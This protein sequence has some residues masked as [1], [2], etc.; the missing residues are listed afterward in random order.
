MAVF[1]G[2]E[3]GTGLSSEQQE[4]QARDA[5][6]KE[7]ELYVSK[8]LYE[9]QAQFLI[10]TNY[11]YNKHKGGYNRA[12]ADQLPAKPALPACFEACAKFLPS[13][14]N[15]TD[16]TRATGPG[17]ATTGAQQ[18]V[19][20]DSAELDKWLLLVEENHDEVAELTSLPALQ[21][22]LERMESQ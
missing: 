11:V 21:G 19:E 22:L 9:Q 8:P 15:E 10:D 3:S 12:L 7:V 18:E 4:E 13:T 16:V 20:N 5:L 2:P 6:R 14:S 17:S 1:T